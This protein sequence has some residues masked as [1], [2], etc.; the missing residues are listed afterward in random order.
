[1]LYD[2]YLCTFSAGDITFFPSL[3]NDMG[4][5]VRSEKRSLWCFK[6]S[7]KN[8]VIFFIFLLSHNYFIFFHKG[9]WFDYRIS[10]KIY[11]SSLLIV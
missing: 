9:K 11:T 6:K 10:K 5:F 2:I 4:R 3:F 8:P 1:M 7:K